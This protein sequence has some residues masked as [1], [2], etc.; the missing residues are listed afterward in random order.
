MLTPM[1]VCRCDALTKGTSRFL[2]EVLEINPTSRAPKGE[3]MSG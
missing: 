1:K 3:R 2:A